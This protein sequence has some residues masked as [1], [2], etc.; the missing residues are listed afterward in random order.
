MNIDS[1]LQ[2]KNLNSFKFFACHEDILSPFADG[3]FRMRS[4]AKFE[5]Y[6][7]YAFRPDLFLPR[8]LEIHPEI[9]SN[10]KT[11]SYEKAFSNAILPE[12]LQMGIDMPK[13][14]KVLDES[15]IADMALYVGKACFSGRLEDFFLSCNGESV[16]GYSFRPED[17]PYD[18]YYI[19][20]HIDLGEI[21]KQKFLKIYAE[22]GKKISEISQRTRR[23]LDHE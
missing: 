18:G 5:L 22:I 4:N 10:R 2:R 20:G 14:K 23:L 12:D 9:V 15:H 13:L 11:T 8:V 7:A 16:N 19:S 1:I 6:H 21:D 3:Y 17:D